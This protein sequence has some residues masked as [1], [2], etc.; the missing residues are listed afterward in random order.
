[1][2]APSLPTGIAALHAAY[3]AGLTPSALL[4]AL[5]ARHDALADPGIFLHRPAPADLDAAVAALPEFDPAR[6]P[7][8]GV[9]V[10]VKDNIDVAGMPTTAACPDF[11]H[12][13]AGSAPAVARL[14]AAGA[15]V[16]GKTNLDQFATGLVGT[17]TPHP[18]PRNAC[19]PDRVPGG[20][21]SGSAVAVAQ[22]LALLAL[23]TDTAGSGRVPAALN[24]LVGLKPS[25]GAIP[26]RG[27]VPACPSLDCISVFANSVA[28]AWAGFAVMAGADDRDPWSR[29][30]TLGTPGAPLTRLGIPRAADLHLDGAEQRAAWDA[31]LARIAPHVTIDEIDLTPFLE[32][33][34]L[35]YEGAFVAERDAAFGH[36]VPRDAMHPVTQRILAGAAR[37]TA[38][39]AFAGLHRL[40]ALRLATLPAW[41]R[42]E[43]LLVPTA[44][45]F[46]TL[47]ELEADPIGPNARLGTYTNFVNLQDLAALAVPAMR[48]PDG[49]PFG[50]TLIGPRGRDA[51]LAA[52]GTQ[53]MQVMA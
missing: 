25:V 31:S 6:Y 30:I 36:L 41:A 3:A 22:G 5:S 46:P 4:Q 44:P 7:L 39:D 18:I 11:A 15:L 10:A 24:G 26:S 13:P 37:F 9:P 19:A 12:L 53:L 48:R 45:N 42:M 28:D 8:W 32:T 21:S 1:M 35:L 14:V 23:G 17:R 38:T 51:A 20:S 40:A 47:A 33:A 29:P 49:L 52:T 2:T 27:V 34:R 50:I 16:I 43:A